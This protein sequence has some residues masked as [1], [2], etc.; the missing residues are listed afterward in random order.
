MVLHLR[1]FK[2]TLL[3]TAKE[4]ISSVTTFN[5]DGEL[6][7]TTSKT[8]RSSGY[9]IWAS[10]LWTKSL[11]ITANNTGPWVIKFRIMPYCIDR[12]SHMR[13]ALNFNKSRSLETFSSNTLQ[14]S[15]STTSPFPKT[16]LISCTVSKNKNREKRL[17][18]DLKPYV[19]A[20]WGWHWHGHGL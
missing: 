19:N 4:W 5:K 2:R 11:T 20:G 12:L 17:V 14:K 8:V 1:G 10:Q 3:L 18:L 13:M 9:L 6:R 7:G 16:V 15:R